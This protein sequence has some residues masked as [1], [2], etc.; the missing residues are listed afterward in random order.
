MYVCVSVCTYIYQC[1]R[2]CVCVSHL[3]CFLRF[4]RSLF[5]Y[6]YIYIYVYMCIYMHGVYDTCRECLSY[7]SVACIPQGVQGAV[8]GWAVLI[9]VCE[10]EVRAARA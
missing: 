6:I 5:I 3:I 1:V 9:Y 4:V 8:Q 2:V 10:C 7:R